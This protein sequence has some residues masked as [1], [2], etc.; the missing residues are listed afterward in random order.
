MKIPDIFKFKKVKAQD[1]KKSVEIDPFFYWKKILMIVFFVLMFVAVICFGLY[2]FV[3]NG[4]LVDTKSKEE[5]QSLEIVELRIDK[6]NKIFE[7]FE[8]RDIERTNIIESKDFVP[9]PSIK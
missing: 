8:N 9:D 5:V 6:L 3:N 1:L 4:K 7:I 2:Y